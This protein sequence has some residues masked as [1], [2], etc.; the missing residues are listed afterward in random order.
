MGTGKPGG[1]SRVPPALALALRG[2]RK[3][4]KTERD[5]AFAKPRFTFSANATPGQAI[6]SFG[7]VF[8]RTEK[9]DRSGLARFAP[10]VGRFHYVVRKNRRRRDAVFAGF[11]GSGDKRGPAGVAQVECRRSRP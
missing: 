6:R 4:S 2:R 10:R 11:G 8:S 3:S 9:T 7:G 5:S 1:L